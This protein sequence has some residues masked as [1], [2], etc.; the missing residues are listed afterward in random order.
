MKRRL[1]A[2][3]LALCMALSLVPAAAAADTETNTLYY[4]SIWSPSAL[5][6]S[7]PLVLEANTSD[8]LRFFTDKARTHEVTENLIFTAD[9]G[10]PA[11]AII[12]TRDTAQDGNGNEVAVWYLYAQKL[13]TGTLTYTENG[14][15]YTLA[16]SCVLPEQGLSSTPELTKE[17]YL[18]SGQASFVVGEPFYYVFPEETQI[19][20]VK[21]DQYGISGDALSVEVLADALRLPA[22]SLEQCSAQ[23]LP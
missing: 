13:G 9:E 15:T 3:A 7:A 11:D 17:T 10:S 23:R 2:L 1:L 18:V 4:Q 21:V 20:S 22:G 12:P 14:T 16:V 6:E 5:V 19:Q 8:L